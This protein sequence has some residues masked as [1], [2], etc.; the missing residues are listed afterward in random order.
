MI[1]SQT[2]KEINVLPPGAIVNNA[3]YVPNVI[4]TQGFDYVDII[5]QLGASDIAIAAMSLSESDVK[6]SA[7]TLTSGVTITGSDYSV[8]P[9]TLPSATDDN[10]LF[11]W[12]V[13]VR[14]QRKRYLLPVLTAGNGSTGTYLTVLAILS[15]ADIMPS[16]AAGRGFTQEVFL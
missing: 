9:L 16:T 6:A 5:V 8:L 3:A 2:M 11:V 4:D 15:E 13:P 1:V 7:T 10:N 14:G 12:H